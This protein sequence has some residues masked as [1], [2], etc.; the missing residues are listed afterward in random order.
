MYIHYVDESTYMHLRKWW[1]FP[2]LRLGVWVYVFGLRLRMYVATHCVAINAAQFIL[3][4][5][6]SLDCYPAIIK[7]D[8]K[9][10]SS[11]PSRDSV[12]KG[13]IEIS[14]NIGGINLKHKCA[15][16]GTLLVGREGS[17]RE[18]Q[19]EETNYIPFSGGHPALLRY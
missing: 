15:N 2:N 8:A 13:S 18:S 10:F 6:R 9:D 17:K 4:V 16:S 14:I 12:W 19:D 7:R 1:A 3:S 5:R 11:V